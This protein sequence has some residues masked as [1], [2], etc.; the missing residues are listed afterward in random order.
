MNAG[1]TGAKGFVDLPARVSDRAVIDA[2]IRCADVARVSEASQ[3]ARSR[4]KGLTCT[5]S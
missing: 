1:L 2:M 3:A 4:Q 5:W